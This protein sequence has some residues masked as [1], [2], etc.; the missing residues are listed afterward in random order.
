MLQIFLSKLF[1]KK[2]AKDT[3]VPPLWGKRIFLDISVFAKKV[4]R[5]KFTQKIPPKE[6]N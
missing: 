1:K 5:P 2:S 6:L 4:V 3:L